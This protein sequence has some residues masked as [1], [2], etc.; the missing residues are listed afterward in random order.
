MIVT[1]IT[2]S[3]LQILV[4]SASDLYYPLNNVYSLASTA[5]A[6]DAHCS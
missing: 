3:A 5:Y 1:C 2:P 6:T 4:I